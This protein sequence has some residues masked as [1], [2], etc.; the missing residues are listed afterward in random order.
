MT[1]LMDK[2][3]DERSE[4]VTAN[5]PCSREGRSLGIGA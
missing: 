4:E 3:V 2:A 5:A 1:L